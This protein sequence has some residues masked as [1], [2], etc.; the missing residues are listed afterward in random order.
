MDELI[1]RPIAGPRDPLLALRDLLEAVAPSSPADV[2]SKQR[3]F[4]RL[5]HRND[6]VLDKA[7]VSCVWVLSKWL[8]AKTFPQGVFAWPPEVPPRVLPKPAP[9]A[10]IPE[11]E[12]LAA[13]A[14]SDV[15]LPPMSSKGFT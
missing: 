7:F 8:M 10:G 13:L 1:P 3:R 14:D 15:P 12:P 6:Y 9:I 2:F 5:L 11:G 4:H